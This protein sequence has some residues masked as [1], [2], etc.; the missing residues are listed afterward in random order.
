MLPS[1]LPRR[2]FLSLPVLLVLAFPARRRRRT[3]CRGRG[4]FREAHPAIAR[5]ALQRLPQRRGQ[6]GQGRVAPRFPAWLAKGRRIGSGD[7]PRQAGREPAHQGGSLRRSQLRMPPKEK[8]AGRGDRR[9]GSLGED[10]RARSA[11][12]DERLPAS[13]ISPGD[14]QFWSFRPVQGLRRRRAVKDAAWPRNRHRSLHPGE[15]GSEGLRPAAAGGPADA[16]PPRDLRPDR[17][18]ADARRDRRVPRDAVA[19]RVRQSRRSA[20]RLARI[21]AS[22][23]AGTGSTSSATPTRPATTPITPSRR[24]T[25]IATGSSTRS[26]Q[27]MP[28]DGSS[29]SRSPATCCPPTRDEDD[30]TAD[31][32][33]RLPGRTPAGSAPTKT[34]AIR[35][36]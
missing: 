10:G 16:H 5:A 15:A 2:V 12:R 22:A 25:G 30:R 8:L 29:A 1:P 20:A 17:P 9:P 4:V 13:S 26:T 21:T 28:Y 14:G 36:T 27:D 19:G 3:G 11:N 34:S 23:G 35:G 31:H 18:A 7:C 6:E 24:C 33:H 32:R